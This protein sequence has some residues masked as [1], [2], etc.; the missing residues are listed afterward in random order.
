MQ[1]VTQERE[2]DR[3]SLREWRRKLLATKA[4]DRKPQR[5]DISTMSARWGN[6]EVSNWMKQLRRK[7]I[8]NRTQLEDFFNW[9]YPTDNFEHLADDE[10]DLAIAVAMKRDEEDS[11]DGMGPNPYMIGDKAPFTE[12]A[13]AMGITARSHW[14]NDMTHGA[15]N[16]RANFRKPNGDRWNF[17]REWKTDN[18]N[19]RGQR[20]VIK[21]GQRFSTPTPSLARVGDPLP[22]SSEVAERYS[23]VAKRYLGSDLFS[24]SLLDQ[25][26]LTSAA[27]DEPFTVA[28]NVGVSSPSPQPFTVASNYIVGPRPY[29]PRRSPPEH[30][31]RKRK[32]T[33]KKKRKLR[34]RKT[35]KR[36]LRKRKTKQTKK[37][38]KNR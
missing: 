7:P 10:L 31:G 15:R 12:H 37:K 30:G 23:V 22:S 35:K 24:H 11:I 33:K 28:S 9:H 18:K 36:K 8:L 34:K 19:P 26:R 32:A 2:R 17:V 14:H 25:K 29:P 1:R 27:Y 4:N 21:N 3:E 38:K 16:R 13:R 6:H 5:F 20:V